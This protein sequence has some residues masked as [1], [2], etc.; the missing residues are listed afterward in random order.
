VICKWI[1]KNLRRLRDCTELSQAQSLANIHK[2]KAAN[3][4]SFVVDFFKVLEDNRVNQKLIRYIRDSTSCFGPRRLG[5]NILINRFNDNS[6]SFFRTVESLLGEEILPKLDITKEKQERL[7]KEAKNY[8]QKVEEVIKY[9]QT[10]AKELNSAMISG[11]D[12]ATCSG[13]LMD[14]PMQG[15][16]FIIEDVSLAEEV[17]EAVPN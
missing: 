10:S 11:F 4:K 13:P 17:K 7:E 5:S 12:L 1:E 6:K 8:L 3:A 9:N 15:A 16:I 2:V 14:D